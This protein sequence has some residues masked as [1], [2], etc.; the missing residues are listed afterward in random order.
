MEAI[1]IEKDKETDTEEM[2]GIEG[3]ED[4]DQKTEKTSAENRGGLNHGT[5]RWRESL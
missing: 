3:I 5:L 1:G 2:K 4:H